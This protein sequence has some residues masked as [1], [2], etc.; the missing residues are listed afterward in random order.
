MDR[1]ERLLE[2]RKPIIRGWSHDFSTVCRRET[3]AEVDEELCHQRRSWSRF[4]HPNKPRTWAGQQDWR[5]AGARVHVRPRG[6][7]I[8]RAFQAA[9]TIRR[10]VTGQARRRPDAGDE[11]YGRTRQGH[12]PGVSTRV[13]TLLAYDAIERKMYIQA[14][15]DTAKRLLEAIEKKTLGA[16]LSAIQSRFNIKDDLSSLFDRAL[17]TRN[18]VMHRFFLH[19]G[20]AIETDSGRDDMLQHMDELRPHLGIGYQAAGYLAQILLDAVRL[21]K[22]VHEH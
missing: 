15:V 11:G 20:L 8:R 16:S 19:H 18:L 6:G 2:A 17:Q 13:S 7:G 9:R 12:S 14:D 5:Q 22:K 4:R 10:H 3:F 1:H 21:L